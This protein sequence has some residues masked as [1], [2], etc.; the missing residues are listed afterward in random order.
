MWRLI[1]LYSEY[2]LFLFC[3]SEETPRKFGFESQTGLRDL[4][5]SFNP[6]PHETS[7]S[8][9]YKSFKESKMNLQI[10]ISTSNFVLIF[11]VVSG[12]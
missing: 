7:Q 12:R 8:C 5:T 2:Q 10:N 4:S 9:E 3:N 6:G 11:L 1:D